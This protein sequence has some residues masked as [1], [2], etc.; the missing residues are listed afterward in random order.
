MNTPTALDA[1]RVSIIM[2][3]LNEE[4]SLPDVLAALQRR[5]LAGGQAEL[6]VAD[7]GSTDCTVSIAAAFGRVISIPRGRAR[8]M[9]AGA[10]VARGEVLLFLHA[11]TLLPFDALNVIDRALARP[12]VVG[13]AFRLRFD[14][15]SRI[16][17]LVA[18]SVNLRSALRHIYTGDQA[19]AIRRDAFERIGG[20]PNIALMEDLEI[21][22]RLRRIGRFVLFPA[23][24]TTSARRHRQTGLGRTLLVMG[25]IRMLYVCGMP[26]ERLCQIYLDIR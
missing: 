21:V 6:I 11:D 9:N 13:G 16:Y 25:L 3:V 7:G 12:G 17:R 4:A 1:P 10:A 19:Y 8:Q 20:Y 26:P 15:D 22:K 23:S 2:P 18:A 5:F 24:V 14:T